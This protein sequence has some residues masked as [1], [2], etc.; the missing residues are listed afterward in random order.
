[1]GHCC[2]A[3][4]ISVLATLIHA[5]YLMLFFSSCRHVYFVPKA[6]ITNSH[7]KS[8]LFVTAQLL[9]RHRQ[10]VGWLNQVA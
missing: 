7:A 4:A 8:D 2:V 5:N 3:Y 6:S 10:A 1:M 9:Q